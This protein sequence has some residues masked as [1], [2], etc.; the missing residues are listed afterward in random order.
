MERKGA[1]GVL[2]DGREYQVEG[3]ELS[4]GVWV[5]RASTLAH[6]SMEVL[7]MDGGV[8]EVLDMVLGHAKAV[9]IDGMSA[10]VVCV[11]LSEINEYFTVFWS[12][13][14]NLISKSKSK[15]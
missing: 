7:R 5:R 8:F 1:L 12:E 15:N 11:Y 13:F 6:A 10:M 3:L 4:S 14:G 9:C 2:T